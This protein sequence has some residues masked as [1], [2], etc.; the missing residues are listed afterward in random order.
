MPGTTVP[1]IPHHVPPAATQEALDYADLHIV[2]LSKGQTPEGRVE[3]AAQVRDALN[4]K[5][6]FYL[7]NHGLSKAENERMLDIAELPFI[8][9][10]EEEKKLYTGNIKEQM[11]YEGYKARQYWH[12][13]S[14]VHDQI[15]HYNI[16]RDVARKEHPKAL[17][18]FLSEIQKFIEYSHLKILHPILRLLA[19]GMELPEETFVEQHPYLGDSGTYFRFMKYW[20]RSK[21]DE[22]KTNNVWLKGH[23][24]S[25]TITMLW[26]QPVAA[27]Q[28]MSPD[29]KW[30]ISRFHARGQCGRCYGVMSGGFYK[31]TIHRVVQ[32]PKDQ[33]GLTRLGIFYFCYPNDDVLLLPRIESPIFKS[34]E[35]IRRYAGADAPTMGL[36]RRS[37]TA[38]YGQ[39]QLPKKDNGTEEEVIHGILLKHYN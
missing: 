35:L 1:A 30:R 16:V 20:P 13:D 23:T 26:S 32:P 25:G 22:L 38:A 36:W 11:S 18:P 3:L 4:V 14:G 9:V 24:D 21:E 37:R 12:I 17:R 28:I 31:A 15:E 33:H 29:G 2:D 8:C 27:L 10:S 34:R 6:F 7:I 5:G 39:K 19:L